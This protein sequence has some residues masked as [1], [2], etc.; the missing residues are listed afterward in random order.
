MFSD[1][2]DSPGL[3]LLTRLSNLGTAMFGISTRAD[4]GLLHVWAQKLLSTGSADSLNQTL[5]NLVHMASVAILS[6][7]S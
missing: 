1:D 7:N 3:T 2:V 6:D 5:M 4:M